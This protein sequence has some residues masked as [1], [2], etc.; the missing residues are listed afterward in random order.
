V[1]HTDAKGGWERG[2]T[3]A[4]TF[5]KLGDEKG[6]RWKRGGRAAGGSEMSFFWRLEKTGRKVGRGCGRYWGK[7]WEALEKGYR[8]SGC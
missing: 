1:S 4:V 2:K 6:R 3:V 8:E 5:Q 7:T